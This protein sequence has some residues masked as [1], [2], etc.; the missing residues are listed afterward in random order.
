MAGSIIR[1]PVNVDSHFGLAVSE[2][3]FSG[4]IGLGV[5]SFVGLMAFGLFSLVGLMA[6]GLFSV[7][8]LMA[9]G[10]FS[11][12]GLMAI[13]LFSLVGLMAIGPAPPRRCRGTARCLCREVIVHLNSFDESVDD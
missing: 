10:M 4:L 11:L 2:V 9:V 12:V 7:V 1:P 5:F 3:V 13:G 6:L 8:G